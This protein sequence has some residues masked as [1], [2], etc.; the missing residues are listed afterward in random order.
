M[1]DESCL[2]EAPRCGLRSRGRVFQ[3][4]IQGSG[5]V[6]VIRSLYRESV[7]RMRLKLDIVS[8]LTNCFWGFVPL[9]TAAAYWCLSGTIN[10]DR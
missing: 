6:F 1:K 7:V 10:F 5:N 3:G 8:Q 4:I 2:L 9:L